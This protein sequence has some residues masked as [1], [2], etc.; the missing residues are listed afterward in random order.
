M[1]LI[2]RLKTFMIAEAPS[3]LYPLVVKNVETGIEQQGSNVMTEM[4]LMETDAKVQNMTVQLSSTM[5]AMEE[6]KIIMIFV[7]LSL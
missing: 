7:S 6:M 1:I 4:T 3:A 5:N 2:A